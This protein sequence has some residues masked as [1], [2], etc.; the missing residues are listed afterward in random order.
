MGPAQGR[1]DILGSHTLKDIEIIDLLKT[2]VLAEY[3]SRPALLRERYQNHHGLIV[4]DEVQKIP[5][6]LDE[7]IGSLKQ[8]PFILLTAPVRANYAE[9]MPTCWAVGLAQNMTPLSYMEVTDFDIE[10]LWFSGLLSPHYLSPD[11]IEACVRILP[12]ILKKSYFLKR[13]PRIFPH[14]ANSCGWPP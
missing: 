3:I 1:Q 14:S 6:I 4:I 7:S 11:P 12:I 13:L 10:R 5:S 9:D 8:G 2:D